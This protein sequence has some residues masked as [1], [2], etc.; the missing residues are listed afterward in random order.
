M[1]IIIKNFHQMFRINVQD[2]TNMQWFALERTPLLKAWWANP[3]YPEVLVLS[4][5]DLNI[6][7]SVLP[8]GQP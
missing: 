2:K 6:A 4:L 7:V 5:D 1:L 8:K 3:L